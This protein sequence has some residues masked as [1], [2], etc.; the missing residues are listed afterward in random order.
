MESVG[1]ISC[2]PEEVSPSQN[3]DELIDWE[4][5]IDV[6]LKAR[7]NLTIVLR[8]PVCLLVEEVYEEHKFV[9][10]LISMSLLA[11]LLEND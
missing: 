5:V 10:Y 9:T 11:S 4:A 7:A 1:R 3:L 6:G 2:S 8:E